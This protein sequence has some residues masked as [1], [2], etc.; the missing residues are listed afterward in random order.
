[1]LSLIYK[2]TE[3]G[4]EKGVER[5]KRLTTSIILRK[6]NQSDGEIFKVESDVLDD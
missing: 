5:R 6:D 4:T 1:M 2:A 3:T